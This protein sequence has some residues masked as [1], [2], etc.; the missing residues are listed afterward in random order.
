MAHF[1]NNFC[2]T[3]YGLVKYAYSW[4]MKRFEACKCHSKSADDDG[5]YENF[6]NQRYPVWPDGYFIF[7]YLDTHN[8]SNQP[9]DYKN[10]QSRFKILPNTK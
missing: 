8:D 9:K 10:C 7:H 5:A 4:F 2:T 1:K 3:K 6:Q